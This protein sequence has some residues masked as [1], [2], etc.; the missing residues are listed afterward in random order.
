MS[1]S[2]LVAWLQSAMGAIL[3]ATDPAGV[4]GKVGVPDGGQSGLRQSVGMAPVAH[5]G[6]FLGAVG[7]H[8][9]AGDSYDPPC[10]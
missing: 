2:H 3:A 10:P 1:L 6:F 7:P 4:E 9:A 8:P 5:A